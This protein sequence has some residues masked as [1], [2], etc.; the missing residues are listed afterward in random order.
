MKKP[1]IKILQMWREEL[2]LMFGICIGNGVYP[3]HY[4][5]IQNF[6]ESLK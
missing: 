2:A 3:I 4:N 6:L 1:E 5:D